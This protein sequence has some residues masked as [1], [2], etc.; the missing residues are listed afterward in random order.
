MIGGKTK[1]I[2]ILFK[3][4]KIPF[5]QL[6]GNTLSVGVIRINNGGY[7]FL[8]EI[9]DAFPVINLVNN[10]KFVITGKILPYC[11]KEPVGKEMNMEVDDFFW[12]PVQE[13]S[14]DGVIVWHKY[15]SGDRCR[16]QGISANSNQ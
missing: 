15:I 9:A 6:P 3:N 14:P 11:F 10:L 1:E 2:I 16:G 5:I 12:Q 7:S 4:M 13:N 8:S